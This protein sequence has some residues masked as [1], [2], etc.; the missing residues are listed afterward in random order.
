MLITEAY[1]GGKYDGFLKRLVELPRRGIMSYAH[2]TA[3]G[4]QE[5]LCTAGYSDVQILEH[6]E[7]GWLCATRRKPA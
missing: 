5:L 3:G 1:K 4:H 2:L 7:N 6:Y